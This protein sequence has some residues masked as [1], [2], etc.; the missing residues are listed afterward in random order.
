VVEDAPAARPGV[1]QPGTHDAATQEV[2]P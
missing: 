2:V 1:A